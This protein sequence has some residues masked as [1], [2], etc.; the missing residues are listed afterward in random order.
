MNE[1]KVTQDKEA[2]EKVKMGEYEEFK[3]EMKG[4]KLPEREWRLIFCPD[5]DPVWSNLAGVLLDSYRQGA[6]KEFPPTCCLLSYNK[7]FVGF[8][9][10]SDLDKEITWLNCQAL[11]ICPVRRWQL[12]GG[13][14]FFGPYT[15]YLQTVYPVKELPKTDDAYYLYAHGW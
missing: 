14:I 9:Y 8:G 15:V 3:R 4:L 6:L 1:S 13:T 5:A 10:Y 11:D 2:I 12:G 7:P